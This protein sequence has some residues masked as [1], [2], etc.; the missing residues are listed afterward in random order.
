[1]LI[2]HKR[3]AERNQQRFAAALKGI[4]LNKGRPDDDDEDDTQ[5]RLAEVKRRAAERA[6]GSVEELDRQEFAGFGIEYETV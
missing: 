1:L 5:K 4:D 6:A 3:K 2:K